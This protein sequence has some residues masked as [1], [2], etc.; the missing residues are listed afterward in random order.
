M[1]ADTV[2]RNAASIASQTQDAEAADCGKPVNAFCCLS[3]RQLL[4]HIALLGT[5]AG[6][7]KLWAFCCAGDWQQSV[8][9]TSTVAQQPVCDVLNTTRQIEVRAVMLNAFFTLPETFKLHSDVQNKKMKFFKP[10][11]MQQPDT[12]V[13]QTCR[14]PISARHDTHADWTACPDALC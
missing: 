13:K 3:V 11:W 14:P 2:L 1:K 5:V 8:T 9:V 6:G 4:C 12:Y 7:G 10:I